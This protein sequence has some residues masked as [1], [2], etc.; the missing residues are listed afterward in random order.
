ML[1]AIFILIL[2]TKL[3]KPSFTMLLN[4]NKTLDASKAREI[5]SSVKYFV[6]CVLYTLFLWPGSVNCAAN[7]VPVTIKSF[8]N[9]VTFPEVTSP[10]E[11]ITVNDSRISAE[12]TAVIRSIPIEVGQMVSI[13]TPLVVLEKRDLELSLKKAEETLKALEASYQLAE[14]QFNRVK[15]LSKKQLI[16]QETLGTR[17]TEF[18]VSR[19]E[20]EAQRIRIKELEREL[21]KTIIKAPFKAIVLEHLSYVGELAMPGTK[22]IHLYDANGIL[23]STKLQLE[24]VKSL[25]HAD[26]IIFYG[27]KQRYPV[28]IHSITPA[29]DLRE[30]SQEVRLKFLKDE[31]LIGTT[32]HL[33]WQSKAGHL[34]AELLVRRG[35]Q[36]GVFT[37][38]KGK[39][40][41]IPLPDA[42]EGRPVIAQL[43]GNT[44]IIIDGRFNV[45]H[46]QAVKVENK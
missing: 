40:N 16:S 26:K 35:K 23:V 39:A 46:G 10:A 6:I 43:P 14:N 11:V 28:K 24:D 37:L 12:V 29:L 13:G 30:R 4:L 19:A 22:L 21:E 1:Y 25:K 44:K 32:G 31:A 9:I 41:F 45:Q 33:E 20:L 3:G 8:D 42:E 36:L 7:P 34:P 5:I 2:N 38:K 27:E 17:R 18:I 15:K